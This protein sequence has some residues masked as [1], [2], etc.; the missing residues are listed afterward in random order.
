MIDDL[1]SDTEGGR[2]WSWERSNKA[3]IGAARAAVSLLALL[4]EMQNRE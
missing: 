2:T 1:D 3:I 4:A